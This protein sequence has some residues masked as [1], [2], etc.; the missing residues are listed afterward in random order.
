VKEEADQRQSG[1]KADASKA[2]AARIHFSFGGRRNE[3][4]QRRL[5]VPQQST[6]DP[7]VLQTLERPQAIMRVVSGTL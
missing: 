1:R 4:G 3:A 7:S 6:I 5:F 2:S